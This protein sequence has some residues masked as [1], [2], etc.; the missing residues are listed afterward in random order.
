MRL[1]L[2][3]EENGCRGL[4]DDCMLLAFVLNAGH[5][6]YTQSPIQSSYLDLNRFIYYL[7]IYFVYS[8]YTKTV[9]LRYM[10]FSLFFVLNEFDFVACL[11]SSLIIAVQPV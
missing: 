2:K 11:R 4:A 6:I 8:G 1:I 3:R 9:M 5:H 7:F 10:F